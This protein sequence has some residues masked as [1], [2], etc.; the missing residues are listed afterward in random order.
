VSEP[1]AFDEQLS[2]VWQALSPPAG[3]EAKV[4]A[5]LGGVGGSAAVA[6]GDAASGPSGVAARFRALRASGALGGAAGMGLLGLGFIAGYFTRPPAVEPPRAPTTAIAPSTGQPPDG[7]TAAP[8]RVAPAMP[9]ESTLPPHATEADATPSTAAPAPAAS[10]PPAAAP[11][12]TGHVAAPQPSGVARR[13]SGR[14]TRARSAA[15]TANDELV[16]LER[17]ER[18]VRGRNPDLA[19]V[20][21]GEIEDRYPGSQLHE[22]RRAIELMALCQAGS[23]LA[24]ELGE[25]FARRYPGSVYGQRIANECGST[26]TNRSALDMDGSEGGNNAKPEKP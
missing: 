4:R 21:A 26:P 10:T 19:L 14:T 23:S 5:R 2:E 11:P 6:R 25:R 16:L 17:A 18:A 24:I 20:L 12:A 15:N 9:A 8:A 1:E 22:E 7:M 3:L 13:A